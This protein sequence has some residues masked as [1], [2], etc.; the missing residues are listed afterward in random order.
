MPTFT[1]TIT[2]AT[3]W[4]WSKIDQKRQRE[5]TLKS[6][7]GTRKHEIQS[8]EATL[9]VFKNSLSTSDGN[10]C[11]KHHS[12]PWIIILCTQTPPPKDTRRQGLL[13]LRTGFSTLQLPLYLGASQRTLVNRKSTVPKYLNKYFEV[14]LLIGI[15][16]SHLYFNFI[17]QVNDGYRGLTELQFPLGVKETDLAH[18]TVFISRIDL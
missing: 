13:R 8:Y 2:S 17:F 1:M 6:L 11:S 18:K 4:L 7:Q 9:D 5:N 15:I 12:W 16:K 3:L 14:Q 10:T